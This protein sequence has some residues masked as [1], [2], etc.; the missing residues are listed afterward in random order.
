MHNFTFTPHEDSL[1]VDTGSSNTWVGANKSYA[2]T[3]TSISTQRSVGDNYNIGSF[4]GSE[5]LDDVVLAPGAI[6]HNMSLA[7]ATFAEGFDGADG[8]LGL[9]PTALTEDTFDN[10]GTETI[11][12]IT[13]TAF[14]QHIIGSKIVGISFQPSQ[15]F[16]DKTGE[17]D[18]G[19]AD[20]AKF[21][22]PL[23]YVPITSVSPST[24]FVGIN[25]ST[26]YGSAGTVILNNTAGVID[27]GCSLLL[28]AS[29]AFE[30]YME[31]TNSTYDDTTGLLAL[32][33]E[34]FGSLESL[35]FTVG[36]TTYE[37]TAD[38]QIWPR[39][40][41]SLIGGTDDNVYITIASDGTPSGTGRDFT[42]GLVW[43][44]RFYVVYD[45]ANNQVGLA[46]TQY[47]N[48]TINSQ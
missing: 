48:S 40:Q 35:F 20:P 15:T 28:L 4:V 44:E 30:R 39:S 25:Q 29:D 27:T 26:T 45:S 34:Q 32:P 36:N 12:T 1:I 11:P 10:N 16:F 41:N 23:S 24:F 5:F 13:D 22:D 2:V 7:V 21:I 33:A 47:T 37:W 38:A 31:A 43:L 3:S 46:N 14:A 42:L 19:A 9:G 8:I 17:L 6:I 18:F